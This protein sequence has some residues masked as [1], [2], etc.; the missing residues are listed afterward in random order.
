MKTVLTQFCHF[1]KKNINSKADELLKWIEENPN[2]K[3]EE[4]IKK[5]DELQEFFKSINN[6]ID[7]AKSAFK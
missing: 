2:S 4:Y 5:A 3:K 7:Q 6:N 1:M